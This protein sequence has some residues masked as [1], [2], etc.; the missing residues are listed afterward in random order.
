MAWEK[1]PSRQ[2]LRGRLFGIRD[3]K[4]VGTFWDFHVFWHPGE[5]KAFISQVGADG[6]LGMGTLEPPSADGSARSEAT[7]YSV[8]GT[9]TRI[10][11]VVR[12]RGDIHA[13]ESF[14]WV[15]GTWQPR[16]SY[17]WHR[18][19]PESATAPGDAGGEG[20]P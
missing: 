10:A 2:T 7:I 5:G 6:T 18:V 1:G 12:N 20:E 17:V 16:R 19:A 11:H 3:G 4:D 8:D 9:T 14:D 13:G 15:D